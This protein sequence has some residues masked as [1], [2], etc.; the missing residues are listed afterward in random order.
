MQSSIKFLDSHKLLQVWSISHKNELRVT[1]IVYYEV[2]HRGLM[3]PA[4]KSITTPTTLYNILQ[5]LI[6]HTYEVVC[7]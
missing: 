2:S 5:Y 4:Y 7:L 6:F 3:S 1:F